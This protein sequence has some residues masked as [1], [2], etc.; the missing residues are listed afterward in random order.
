[1]TTIL[2]FAWLSNKMTHFIDEKLLEKAGFSDYLDL[3]AY[4]RERY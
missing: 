2:I 3:F 4:I 1:M